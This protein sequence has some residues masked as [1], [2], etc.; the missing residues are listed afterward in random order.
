MKG[1]FFALLLLSAYFQATA[2]ELQVVSLMKPLLLTMPPTGETGN[3]SRQSI[4]LRIPSK[5]A[6]VF[7]AVTVY[8]KNTKLANAP[9]LH[10]LDQVKRLAGEPVNPTLITGIEKKVRPVENSGRVHCYFLL[11][12]NNSVSYTSRRFIDSQPFSFR[13]DKRYKN[14]SGAEA[15]TVDKKE[16][17]KETYVGIENP[18]ATDSVRIVFEAVAIIDGFDKA[19]AAIPATVT[20]PVYLSSS[21]MVE[22]MPQFRGDLGDFLSQN[23]RYPAKARKDGIQARLYVQF[24]IRENGSVDS[25]K[26]MREKL[27]YAGYYD[28][29]VQPVD[30]GFKDEA[31]RVIRLMPPWKP[32]KKNGKPIDYRY[33]LPFSFTLE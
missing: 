16:Q 27:D 24:T 28:K 1:Y 6:N 8:P 33:M 2:A 5:A 7:Y 10:L 21:S 32:G 12:E 14:F 29:P 17:G 4:S 9:G 26:V 20:E 15:I 11:P 23:I 30:Y 31:I 22:E 19:F 18:S 13:E 3:G 25:I